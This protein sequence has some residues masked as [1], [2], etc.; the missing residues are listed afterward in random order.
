MKKITTIVAALIIIVAA[1]SCKK[2]KDV[3]PLAVTG[4]ILS[5]IEYPSSGLV[6]TFE[7][8]SEGRLVTVKGD[9]DT[10]SYNYTSTPF[11]YEI[12][13]SSN[14]KINDLGNTVFSANKLTSYDY[15]RFNSSGVF[16]NSVTN[17][18]Y[19][20]AEGYQ[21]K[22]EY[23][24]YIY[25]Y[26][27]SQGNTVGYTVSDNTGVRR[28]YTFEYYTDMPNKINLNL[29]E[30]WYLDQILSDMEV[31]GKKNKNLLKR[32]TYVSATT[33]EVTDYTYVLNTNGLVTQCTSTTVKNGGAPTSYTGKFSYQ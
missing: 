24:G 12:W 1:S 10:Y 15:R 27:I 17:S 29:F 8:N 28:T 33:T 9:G 19:Y 21:I 23:G 26:N 25:N 2:S 13:N 16:S 30:N 22:K 18:I 4:S 31:H 14:I 5:K 6:Q 20:D 11:G 3:M 32:V 7:Y